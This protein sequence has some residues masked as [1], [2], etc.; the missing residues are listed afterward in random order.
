MF[1]IA[2]TLN[3]EDYEKNITRFVCITG[4]FADY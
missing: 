4:S 1:V 2:L 3:H